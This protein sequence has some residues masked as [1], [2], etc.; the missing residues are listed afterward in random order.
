MKKVIKI[1]ALTLSGIITFVVLYFLFA[2]ILSVIPVNK[3]PENAKEISVY[4]LTN[5]AHTDIVVPVKTDI[6][7]WSEQIKYENTL[8]NDTSSQLLAMGWGDKGFYLDTPSW[9]DLKFS[10]AFK[11]VFGINTAAIHATYYKELKENELCKKIEISKEQYKDLVAYIQKSFLTNDKGDYINIVTDAN[12]GMNDAFY[13]GKGKFNMF[14]TCNA[15]TNRSLK[16]CGQRAC[17]WTP[18]DKGIFYHYK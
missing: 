11:A 12:Y 10:T 1:I 7:D 14:R 5:G 3:N 4:I 2:F 9:A 15:W 13:E 16:A 17:V 8:A 18:F 6:I